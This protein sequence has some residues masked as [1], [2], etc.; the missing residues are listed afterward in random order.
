[1]VNAVTYEYEFYDMDGNKLE[2][3]STPVSGNTEEGI[4][5]SGDELNKFK[6]KNKVV[7]KAY[8]EGK[9]DKTIEKIVYVPWGA[10]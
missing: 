8:V 4:K 1:M 2:I 10:R 9:L 5:V 3:S 6:F 7:L